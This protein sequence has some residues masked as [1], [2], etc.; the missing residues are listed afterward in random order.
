V[1]VQIFVADLVYFYCGLRQF[2][3]SILILL[4]LSGLGLPYSR[5]G[6][7]EWYTSGLDF[8][9]FCVMVLPVVYGWRAPGNAALTLLRCR[10]RRAR[11][12]LGDSAKDVERQRYNYGLMA[13]ARVQ[14]KRLCRQAESL[15]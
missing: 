6:L 13:L 1:V 8:R 2:L 10:R 15:D 11:P 12:D 4:F 14:W 3:Y 9:L 7:L 5:L